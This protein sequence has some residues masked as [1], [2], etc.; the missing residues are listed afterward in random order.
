[1]TRWTLTFLALGTVGALT[2][3]D[4]GSTAKA[5]YFCFN[6]MTDCSQGMYWHRDPFPPAPS[7][8]KDDFDPNHTD[9]WD[10]SCG[11]HMDC[12]GGSP[13]PTDVL[14]LIDEGA[15]D[16]VLGLTA[17]ADGVLGLDGSGQ[18]LQV[19]DCGG[20]LYAHLPLEAIANTKPPR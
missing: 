19:Y 12:Q 2:P 20:R 7:G 1:M 15:L 16:D 5:D 4:P 17:T 3:A 13:S 6:C 18:W 14:A 11:Y 10:S 8:D 9:C